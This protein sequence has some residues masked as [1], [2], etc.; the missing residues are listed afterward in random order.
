MNWFWYS[1]NRLILTNF[2]FL[3]KT[4]NESNYLIIFLVKNLQSE[5]V[6]L[7]IEGT[8]SDEEKILQ[9]FNLAPLR[10]KIEGSCMLCMFKGWSTKIIGACGKLTWHLS[11]CFG[12]WKKS[13]Q[14]FRD[15]NISKIHRITTYKINSLDNPSIRAQLDSQLI[16]QQ[17]IARKS[18]LKLFS[19][20]RYLLRQGMAFCG[21]SADDG[22]YQQLLKLRA[23]DDS[24]FSEYLNYTTNFTSPHAQKK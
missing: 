17:E 1:R 6:G 18:L 21:H 4:R 23:E 3:M 5:C 15:H 13:P 2:I 9:K 14:R 20:E 11:L 16:Q 12:N 7:S 24:N 22:N 10:K 19:S 8:D